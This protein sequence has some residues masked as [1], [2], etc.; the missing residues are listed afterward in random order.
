M[1][2]AATPELLA[3]ID[4]RKALMEAAR[5]GMRL[6]I[7]YSSRSLGGHTTQYR[8][9]CRLAGIPVIVKRVLDTPPAPTI[10]KPCRYK[11]C[12][13]R[14]HKMHGEKCPVAAAR[15]KTGGKSGEGD[16]KRRLGDTN[17]NFRAVRPCG[18]P[19]RKHLPGCSKARPMASKYVRMVEKEA[20][21]RRVLNVRP[22]EWKS[23]G[24]SV[25]AVSDYLRGVRGVCASCNENMPATTAAKVHPK[26]IMQN[27]VRVIC[28]PCNGA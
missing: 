2:D 16:A 8:K 26:D 1:T 6:K 7:K 23:R 24:L 20:E 27:P 13:G 14:N 18:C 17:G 5:E 11:A 3:L 21:V 25:G 4:E 9:L 22:V 19:M 10:G 28:R 15:G 12:K